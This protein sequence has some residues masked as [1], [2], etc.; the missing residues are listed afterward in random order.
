MSAFNRMNK[1]DQEEF[2]TLYNKFENLKSLP[3]SKMEFQNRVKG[4]FYSMEQNKEKAEKMFKILNI[5]V[6]NMYSLTGVYLKISRINHSCRAN[7]VFGKGEIRAVY[8]IE[9]GQ[10]INLD[11]AMVKFIYSKKATKF[12]EIFTLLLTTVHA[13]KSTVKILQNFVAFSKSKLGFK[14]DLL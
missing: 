5:Y 3:P 9:E 2:L 7:A 14:I 8:K 11:Y 1:S 10:E 13:V 6:T 12:W 4:Y